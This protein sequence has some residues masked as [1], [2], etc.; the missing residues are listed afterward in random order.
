[1]VDS[2]A[3]VEGALNC[4]CL[5]LKQG[6]KVLL[7]LLGEGLCECAYSTDAN[8]QDGVAVT[9]EHPQLTCNSSHLHNTHSCCG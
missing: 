5:A 2:E 8:I 9:A 4:C 1:L 6:N 7:G 3:D